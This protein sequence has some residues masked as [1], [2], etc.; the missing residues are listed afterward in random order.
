MSVLLVCLP[1]PLGISYGVRQNLPQLKFC[2]LMI[3]E[4]LEMDIN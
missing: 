2:K 4:I 3:T 1:S